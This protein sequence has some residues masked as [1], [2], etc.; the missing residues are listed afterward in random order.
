MRCRLMTRSIITLLIAVTVIGCAA[1]PK[2]LESPLISPLTPPIE[3]QDSIGRYR[4]EGLS[5]EPTLHDG[6]Y[7]SSDNLAYV[8]QRPQ[9]GERTYLKRVIGLPG[10]TIEIRGGK[11]WI[12]GTA[13]E[14]AYLDR[15][16]NSSY[17]A[18][19]IEPDHYFVLGDNRNNSSDS[20][21][22]GAIP[23]DAVVGRVTFVYYPF[24]QARFILR[25]K[26]NVSN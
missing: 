26:Y 10:E 22:Y 15:P 12:N 19:V 24:S 1:I 5:M 20:R 14:E 8:T 23:I 16:T 4:H 6:E 17:A 3:S 11:V 21:T 2:G 18:R 13:L 9:R 7:L 25:P